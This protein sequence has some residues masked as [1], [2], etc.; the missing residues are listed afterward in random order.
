VSQQS[1]AATSATNLQTG[2]DQVLTALQQTFNSTSGVNIDTEL[3]NLINL[4]N[5]Y[6]ANARVLSTIEQMMQTL[7]QS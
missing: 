1:Q 2:Q 6:A 4:Q 3:S 5:T 7:I